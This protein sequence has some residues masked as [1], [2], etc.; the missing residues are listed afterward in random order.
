MKKLFILAVALAIVAFTFQQTAKAETDTFTFN[1]SGNG[2]TTI[3]MLTATQQGNTG[4]WDITSINNGLFSDNNIGV[5]NAAMTL[6]PDG[7][8]SPTWLTSIGGSG[9]GYLSPDGSEVYDNLLYSPGTPLN[10]DSWGGLLFTAGGYEV[11]IGAWGNGYNGWVSVLGET[12]NFVDNGLSGEALNGEITPTPEPSPLFLLGTG[13]LGLAGF[14][15]RRKT[16]SL[17]QTA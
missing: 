2:I 15:F 8:G 3:G 5:S 16:A 1:L 9:P 11:G 14:V 4:V 6:V 7:A 17:N 12:N 13:I 10:L